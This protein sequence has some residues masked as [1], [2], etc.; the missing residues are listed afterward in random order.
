MF[1]GHK[2]DKV[3]RHRAYV[4]QVLE[5]ISGKKIDDVPIAVPIAG[6]N[7]RHCQMN[8]SVLRSWL[9]FCSGFA[10][11][12]DDKDDDDIPD[13]MLRAQDKMKQG[14]VAVVLGR[15]DFQNMLRMHWRDYMAEFVG[16]M[17]CNHA[18]LRPVAHG[19]KPFV[20]E[21][22][23][24]SQTTTPGSPAFTSDHKI[25]TLVHSE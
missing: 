21:L 1:N 23:T 4:E 6:A 19:A 5:S 7:C 13:D 15:C 11:A 16:G 20:P 24:R 25:R 2:K 17:H 9:T 12:I 14:C 3:D 18:G 10:V 22:W 8:D